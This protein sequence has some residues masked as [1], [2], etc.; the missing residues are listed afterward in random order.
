M[1][2]FCSLFFLYFWGFESPLHS[3]GWSKNFLSVSI[4]ASY[5]V[6]VTFEF[7]KI[8]CRKEYF[9][10]LQSLKCLAI[11]Q[12]VILGILRGASDGAIAQFQRRNLLQNRRILL[13]NVQWRRIIWIA[14]LKWKSIIAIGSSSSS[15]NIH[16]KFHTYVTKCQVQSLHH[17][18]ILDSRGVVAGT[19]LV[20][21]SIH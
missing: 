11:K 19:N 6:N 5:P 12:P 14:T 17:R 8:F 2:S 21:L 15:L 9:V 10:S 18:T 3:L 7:M 1:H 16:N 4:F 20:L 13:K